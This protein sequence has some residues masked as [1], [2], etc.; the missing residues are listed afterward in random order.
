MV[1]IKKKLYRLPRQGKIFGVC[2]G[3]AEYFDV[4]VTLMRA[5][6]VT[7]AFL[8][9]GAMVFLYLI[10]AVVLP[11]IDLH[12]TSKAANTG[13]DDTINER[14]ERLGRDWRENDASS[15]SRNIIGVGLVVIGA[16]LLMGQFFPEI[17]RLRW[18]IVWPVGLI[19]IGVLIIIRR[20][21]ER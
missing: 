18:E 3:L 10:L 16:W 5:I 2:A 17:F 4:D 8:T 1:D 7:F 6:F 20:G 19:L 9:G 15:K 11:P 12:K 14:V 13:S 21:Y